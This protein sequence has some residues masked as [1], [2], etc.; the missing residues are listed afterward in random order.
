MTPQ[1]EQ[2]HKDRRTATAAAIFNHPNLYKVC[3]QCRSIAIKAASACPMCHAYRWQENPEDVKAT[4]LA[5]SMSAFP[6]TSG[7]VPRIKK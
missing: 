4:A 6:L 2:A 5:S 1:E 3:D 7:V